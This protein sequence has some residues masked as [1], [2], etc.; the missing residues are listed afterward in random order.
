MLAAVVAVLLVG[1]TTTAVL[2]AGR[3]NPAPRPPPAAVHTPTPTATPIP[4]TPLP[5]A[6]T[7]GGSV[8]FTD[9]DGNFSASFSSAPVKDSTSTPVNGQQLTYVQ[10]TNLVN[11]D[12]VEVVAY[13]D[14][15]PSIPDNTPNV[16]LSAG[17]QSAVTHVNGTI[18]SKMFAT[19]QGFPSVDA[20]VSVPASGS[21]PSG[22]LGAR[23]ILAGHTVFEVL[24][25]GL[26]NPP[27]GFA[28]LTILK[29][30]P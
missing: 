30:S 3:H 27:A 4:P 8:A 11:P 24:S 5:T 19:V 13:A 14:Y 6:D 1:G 26:D 23:L 20:I 2:L 9:P 28:P 29:H 12:V 17:I 15:P 25:T 7:S 22:F 16:I 10:F 18:L 21:S